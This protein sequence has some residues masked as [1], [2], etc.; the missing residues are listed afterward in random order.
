MLIPRVLFLSLAH[1]ERSRANVAKLPKLGP[2]LARE[3]LSEDVSSLL[4]GAPGFDLHA[5]QGNYSGP[6]AGH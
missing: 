5:R 6:L 1:A 3:L 2:A 4:I